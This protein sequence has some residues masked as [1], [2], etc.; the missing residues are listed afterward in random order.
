MHSNGWFNQTAKVERLVTEI[1]DR[2]ESPGTW[3]T[4]HEE[5]P[6][7]VTGVVSKPDSSLVGIVP[8][9][10]LIVV[11]KEADVTE[12]GGEWPIERDRL[13]INGKI[14]YV[15]TV[16]DQTMFAPFFTIPRHKIMNLSYK[17]FTPVDHA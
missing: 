2:V 15:A 1:V 8:I 14:Y 7:A 5:L 4:L 10:E 12:A 3:E 11:F 6:C 9:H 17:P 13:T 16:S